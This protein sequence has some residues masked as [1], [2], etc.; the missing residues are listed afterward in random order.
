VVGPFAPGTTPVQVAYQL[1]YDSPDLRFEQVFPVAVQQVTAGVQ[2]VGALAISSP[3]FQQTR[4]LSTDDGVVFLIGSGAGLP[5]G[6]KL[7]WR[8]A[9]PLGPSAAR[10]RPSGPVC[11][12]G[13]APARA[14][15]ARTATPRRIDWDRTL[16][17]PST[18]AGD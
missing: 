10:A 11:P 7:T 16:H 18:A 9:Q 12:P 6:G 17:R 13:L 15:G 1:R 8:L 14:G 4:S 3:Q 5:A 2:K